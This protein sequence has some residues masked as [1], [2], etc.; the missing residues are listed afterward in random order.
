MFS[1]DLLDGLGGLVSVVEGDGAHVVVEDVS[2][3]N[4][5][6]NVATDETEFT[7]D[8]GSSSP[9]ESPNLRSIV[10]E[11]RIGVLEVG[12]GH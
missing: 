3:D 1:H 11:G 6:K 7:I 5:V 12:D 10:G 2:L 4:S 8:G 9:S